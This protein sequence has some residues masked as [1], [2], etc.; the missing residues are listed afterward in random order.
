MSLPEPVKSHEEL[1]FR[2]PNF[3]LDPWDDKRTFKLFLPVENE[4]PKDAIARR[5]D[6]FMD[7]RIE[8]EGYKFI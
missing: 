2:L 4:H 3:L 6:I 1:G 8:P 7:A 5:I